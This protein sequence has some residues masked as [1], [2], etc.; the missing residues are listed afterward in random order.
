VDKFT[1][2]RRGLAGDDF[3]KSLLIK[4]I[5]NKTSKMVLNKVNETVLNP[6]SILRGWFRIYPPL[7]DNKILSVNEFNIITGNNI[8]LLI[9]R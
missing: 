5:K 3:I 6:H 7:A 9:S 1:R 4:K 8:F 2:L